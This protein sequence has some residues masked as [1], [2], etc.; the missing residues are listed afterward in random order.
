MSQPTPI[1]VNYVSVL[2][3]LNLSS[4][5]TASF[6][7]QLE[8]ILSYVELLEKVNV[9]GVEPTAHAIPRFNVFRD[10]IEK[11]S[12]NPEVALQNAPRQANQLFLVP[13][14]ID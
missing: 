3:R 7:T 2:A 4:E 12:L 6:Q 5:E 11:P 10:D 13:N 9:D 14:V 8:K 1:D